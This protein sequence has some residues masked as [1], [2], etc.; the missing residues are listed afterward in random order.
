MRRS[1]YP[2]H[3]CQGFPGGVQAFAKHLVQRHW[4]LAL[5]R[6][7]NFEDAILKCPYHMNFTVEHRVLALKLDAYEPE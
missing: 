1:F 5:D 6:L 4:G 2:N 3:V 7:Q